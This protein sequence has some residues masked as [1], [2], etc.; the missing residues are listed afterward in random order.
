[1]AVRSAEL[2]RGVEPDAEPVRT[3]RR[4]R[5]LPGGRAVVGGFLVMVAML[6]V[7]VTSISAT[8]EPTQRYVVARRDLAPGAAITGADLT[9]VAMGLPPRI[10]SS[11][12][13]TDTQQLVGSIVIGPIA[14][15]E[16]VQASSVIDK[17]GGTGEREMSIPVDADRSVAGGLRPGDRVDVAATFGTGD[18]AYSIFV[19]RGARVL[20]RADGGGPLGDRGRET[21]TLSL[22][23]ASDALALAHAVSAGQLTVVRSTGAPEA[24]GD[25]YRAPSGRAEDA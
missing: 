8:D 9:T 13:F 5:S 7:Y 23:S 2:E 24:G 3:L 16:L 17:R 12:A 21:L 19:V 4:R 1:M 18:Q 25:P 6:G 20:A 11:R 10:A 15:G 14:A 22:E